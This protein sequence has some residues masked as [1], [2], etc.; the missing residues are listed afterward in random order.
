MSTL[1]PDE[2]RTLNAI[3]YFLLDDHDEFSDQTTN[4]TFSC[5]YQ[6]RHYRGVRFIK[7]RRKYAAEIRKPKKKGSKLWLGT[8]NTAEEAAEAYD[9]SVFQMRGSKA[10]L[11][12]PSNVELGVYMDPFLH[13][14]LHTESQKRRKR[15]DESEISHD[16][17][18]EC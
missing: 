9:R 8:F 5:E 11:N 1:T 10:I 3:A 4:S 13:P 6:K 14:C 17:R 2:A 16:N 18:M 15:T 12:F 7:P